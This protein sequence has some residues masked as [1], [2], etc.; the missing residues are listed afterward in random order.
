MTNLKADLPATPIFAQIDICC[1]AI[2]G[3]PFVQLLLSV[4]TAC[5]DLGATCAGEKGKRCVY[6]EEVI[7]SSGKIELK[8]ALRAVFQRFGSVED[9]LVG[10]SGRKDAHVF[11]KTAASAV[12]SA[13]CVHLLHLLVVTLPLSSVP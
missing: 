7:P 9:V 6:I 11:F 2:I 8:P 12:C 5:V 4:T 3:D 1:T 13:I 10:V